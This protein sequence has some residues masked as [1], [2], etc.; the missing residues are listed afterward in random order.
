MSFGRRRVTGYDTR[1]GRVVQF[2]TTFRN[3]GQTHGKEI[4]LLE[5]RCPGGSTSEEF[6]K[7][8]V[9]GVLWISGVSTMVQ[10]CVFRIGIHVLYIL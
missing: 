6:E 10:H 2:G 1:V 5:Q 4:T 9:T 7:V 3:K 8:N